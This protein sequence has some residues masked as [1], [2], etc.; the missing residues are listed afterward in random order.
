[1]AALVALRGLS[2]NCGV[3]S[4][5]GALRVNG[6][7]RVTSRPLLPAS[8]TALVPY[9][10]PPRQTQQLVAT[11]SVH[12]AAPE[13]EQAG[14]D[15]VLHWTAEKILT[16]I[17]MGAIPT[18]FIMPNAATEYFLALC[19]SLHAHWGVE[20]I[21]VDYIRP[22]VFGK[23]IPKLAVGAVYAISIAT[24]G[25]LCY[26]NYTDVGIVNAVKLLWKL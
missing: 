26:F 9:S 18:A 21:V 11:S 13:V 2:R 20:A 4:R 25:G 5:F 23:V 15:H 17:L 22:S 24:L 10:F 19:L 1:M 14:H 6:L 8:S 16:V 12:R 7:Y 3:A